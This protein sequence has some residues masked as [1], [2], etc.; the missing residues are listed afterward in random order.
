MASVAEQRGWISVNVARLPGLPEDILQQT[1]RNGAA[2][3]K[4]KDGERFKSINI[5][6][7]FSIEREY[8]RG[9]ESNWRSRFDFAFPMLRSYLPEYIASYL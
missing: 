5:A 7:V 1:A 8:A 6:S 2:F 3:L 9:I 4:K